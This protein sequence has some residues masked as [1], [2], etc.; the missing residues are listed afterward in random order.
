[1]DFSQTIKSDFKSAKVGLA[2]F[3]WPGECDSEDFLASFFRC[4]FRMLIL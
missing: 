1:M 3:S 2:G 4:C